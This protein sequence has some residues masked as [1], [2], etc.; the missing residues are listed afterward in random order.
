[1][2][3]YTMFALL[4]H[5]PTK[6]MLIQVD[7]DIEIVPNWKLREENSDAYFCVDNIHQ[8]YEGLENR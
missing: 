4:T 7:L 2:A 6:L 1:M 8:I 5:G 3:L